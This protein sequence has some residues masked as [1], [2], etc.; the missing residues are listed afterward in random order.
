MKK[1]L[2]FLAI[3]IFLSSSAKSQLIYYQWNPVS[4][5]VTNNLNIIYPTP[6][7]YVV[8]G[9]DGKLLYRNILEPNWNVTV[10]GVSTNLISLYGSPI[11]YSVGASGV[12]LKSTD[13]GINWSSVTSPTVN[14][15]NSVSAFVSPS[16]RIIGA[17]GGKIFTTTNNGVNW[18]EIP[19]GT[20][21][22][23]RSIYYD[24]SISQFRN[25]ICGDNGTFL[26]LIYLLP[27][28]VSTT[29]IPINTGVSNNLYGVT[30]LGDTSK[31]M[32]VGS[33][34]MILKSTESGGTWVQQ[35][36]GTTNTLRFVY[37]V[38]A[39]EI[40]TGGDNG[41]ILR[42]TNG[43]TNWFPQVVNSS[44]NIY[45]MLQTSNL[46]ALAVGSGGTILETNL[47]NPV[48]DSTLKRL[49]LDGNNISSYFQTSGIFNQNTTL[50]NSPGFEWPK[51]SGKYAM[52]T[53]GLSISA[54]VNGNLRQ[55]MCSYGGEYKT[56]QI[57]NGVP[58]TT[59][60]MNKIWKVSAGENCSTSIDWANWGMI[61]PYG[62]PYRD[63]NNNG[64]YD[65]CT[66]IPG[67]RNASQ[68]LFM[69]L[70]DGYPN[71]HRPGE[72]FGGGTLP[73]NCD[74]KITAYTYGDTNLS[75]VQ[76]IKYDIINRGNSAWNNLYMALVGDYDLG[77]SEDDFLC[78]DSTRNMWI[79]YNGDNNDGTGS[80]PTYGVNPPAVGMRVLKFP[81]NKT[82]APYDTLKPSVGV[83][84]SC[85]G[86]S[87]PVCE[88]DPSGDP[89]GAYL[90]MKGFKKDGSRWMSPMFTPPSPVK[91]LY[92]G[93][94]ETNYGWTELK[95]MIRNCGGDIG[96]YQ[97]TN[98]PGD[99]RFVLSMGKDNFTMNPGD[100][101]T[102]IV[103]Q[104]I[105]RGTSNLNSVTKLKQ[106]ADVVANYTVG[107]NQIGTTVPSNFVL[108]Q[109]YPNPFN[110]ETKI[111]FTIPAIQNLYSNVT[112]L[113]VFD[114]LGREVSVLVNDMLSPGI[115]EV[116]FDGSK[117]ASGFYFYRLQWGVYSDTKRMVLLK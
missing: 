4:S 21:N 28:P 40:W 73:L 71:S 84:T 42:T 41:T 65:P 5:P 61:V 68:T 37:A 54:M 46:K 106:L 104:F 58:E 87:D 50:G 30:A 34:G 117:L 82:V 72:G 24:A 103:A 14:N 39:N 57:I 85:G 70:T 113:K 86:C 8:A 59:P 19:S 101:Q 52:F 74:L 45:S 11:L 44:A 93:D 100:S 47:P 95:G 91:F 12:I 53:S 49:K 78:M 115:Y 10:S 105:A 111:K 48:S 76:F 90:L 20:T 94:P 13:N 64:Q 35:T 32:V 92:S 96:A 69:I 15:I 112:T 67:M 2:L 107:I 88:W 26:K 108:S 51:G 109:N 18:T 55:A 99:R 36:S 16:Y 98:Q 102:I 63:V 3:F 114:M 27:L 7:N 80:P 81:V 17:D 33:G 29:V 60:Y 23:L 1:L 22:S 110:P 31:I 62:A 56:G 9:N 77:V 89:N 25:Y 75:N 38:N 79:G 116:T 97:P 6:S 43:G 66:D 83:K